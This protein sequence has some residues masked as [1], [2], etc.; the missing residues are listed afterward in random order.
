M[1][2]VDTDGGQNPSAFIPFCSFGG[3]MEIVG[4]TSPLFDVPVCSSFRS[5]IRND[6]LC[7]EIDLEKLRD[8]NKKEKQ[9][10]HGL[11]MI[12]DYNEDRQIPTKTN[13]E[14]LDMKE[15]KLSENE[16]I[17]TLQIHLDTISM[18]DM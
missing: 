9:L 1:H 17:D 5:K 3:D 7:Y 10:K 11:V 4:A 6:Q 13:Q 2:I 15:D 12:L 16:N 14:A 8:E 18:R